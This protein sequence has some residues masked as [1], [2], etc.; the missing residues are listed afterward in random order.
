MVLALS[1]AY[2]QVLFN[3]ENLRVANAQADITQS[4]VDRTKKL[5]DAGTAPKANLLDVEAQLAQEQLNI[6][7]VENQ[8]TISLVCM[9]GPMVPQATPWKQISVA[10]NP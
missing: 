3:I 4:Q 7:D 10:K 5:V 9:S 1:Q 6:V 8:L 2:L